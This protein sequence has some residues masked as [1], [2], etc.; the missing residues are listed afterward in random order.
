MLRWSA[1]YT[2]WALALLSVEILIGR[3]ASDSLIRPYLGDVLVIPLLYC[4]IVS[5]WQSRRPARL[6]WLVFGFALAVEAAQALHIADLLGFTRPSLIRTI[7][8]T[9]ADPLD[10]VAYAVGTALIIAFERGCK[11]FKI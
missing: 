8:G 11:Q 7:I 2:A 6:P 10:I 1:I 9:H 4:L 3:Y 5:I